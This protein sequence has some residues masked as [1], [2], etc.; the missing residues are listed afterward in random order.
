MN[1]FTVRVE[2]HNAA[3]TDYERLHEAMRLAGF[4]RTISW[5]SENI[6]YRLPWGEYNYTKES[7]SNAV[8]SLAKGVA[9]T[10]SQSFEILVTP[11]GG[12]RAKY[13]LKRA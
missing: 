6:T 10:V 4:T 5:D 11:A 8:L 12:P 1:R 3:A 13:N 7:E 2:L 9:A